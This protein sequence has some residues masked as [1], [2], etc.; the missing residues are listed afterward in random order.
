LEGIYQAMLNN[1]VNFASFNVEEY[2]HFERM[3]NGERATQA[4]PPVLGLLSL[5]RAWLG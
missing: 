5:P 4:G 2:E 1:F 3:E